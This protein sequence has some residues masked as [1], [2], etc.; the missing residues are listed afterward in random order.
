MCKSKCLVFL[1]TSET[2]SLD[3]FSSM[4]LGFLP[5]Y[6]F[7]ASYLFCKLPNAILMGSLCLGSARLWFAACNSESEVYYWGPC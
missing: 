6:G 5:C 2:A 7:P 1:A 3:K 4:I